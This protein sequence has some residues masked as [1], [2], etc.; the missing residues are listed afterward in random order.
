MRQR[1]RRRLLAAISGLSM[2]LVVGCHGSDSGASRPT[3]TITGL[4]W[5]EESIDPSYWVSS[6]PNGNTAFYDFWIHYDG[7]ITFDDL[8]Y[9]RVYLP[10]GSYWNLARSADRLDVTN[11]TIGGW[12]RWF[13]ATPNVLPI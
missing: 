12:H 2:Q 7:D 4:G 5:Y 10:D 13:G 9:A 6:P 1:T 8:Q 11:K 3:L